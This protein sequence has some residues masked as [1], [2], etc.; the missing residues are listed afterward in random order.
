MRPIALVLLPIVLA[1]GLALAL[2]QGHGAHG[3][4][5]DDRFEH[6][7]PDED[8]TGPFVM[9]SRIQAASG[10][11]E[12]LVAAS[13]ELSKVAREQRGLA[14]YTVLADRG[15][16]SVE[17]ITVWDSFEDFVDFHEAPGLQVRVT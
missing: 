3:H 16:G 10:R 1:S 13:V 7:R 8:H 17:V 9:V 4:G 2:A 14:Q 12:R 11:F 6:L 15:T 5:A